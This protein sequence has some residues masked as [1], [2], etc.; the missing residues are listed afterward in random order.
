MDEYPNR[1]GQ[2]KEWLQKIENAE[3]GLNR[4]SQA[5]LY[6]GLHVQSD[7]SVIAREWAPGAEQVYLTGDF[8][9]YSIFYFK[10]FS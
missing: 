7:N 10:I 1:H 5:Y 4:F 8:S 3:G 2:F 9:K 6:Y